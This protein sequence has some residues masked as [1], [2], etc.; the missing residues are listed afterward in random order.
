MT[1][2]DRRNQGM[3]R[4]ILVAWLVAG[5]ADIGVACTYY[6]LT[7]GAHP[8]RILQGIAAGLLGAR[9]FDGG[10][11]T[12]ALGLL[13]HYLIALIWTVIY[14]AIAVRV[15]FLA[16]HRVLAGVGYGV[17]VSVV[18]TFVVLPSSRVAHRP[19]NASFFA[20]ATVILICAIGLPLSFLAAR[21]TSRYP[22]LSCIT[23]PRFASSA[24]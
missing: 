20:V 3:A 10:L 16:R 23:T 5:T 1:P 17:F 21:Y 12:A 9:A 4:A 24:T 22:R 13:C 8:L 7:A 11:A 15:A 19:F 6:P 18:M 14:F 2:A